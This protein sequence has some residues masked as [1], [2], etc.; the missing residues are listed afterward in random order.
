M[1]FMNL[2]DLQDL[3][4]GF[5]DK[6]PEQEAQYPKKMLDGLFPNA[7]YKVSTEDFAR[8]QECAKMLEKYVSRFPKETRYVYFDSNDMSRWENDF[9]PKLVHGGP[10][11]LDDQFYTGNKSVMSCSG[12]GTDGAFSCEEFFQFL[13]RVYKAMAHYK[14]QSN[15]AAVMQGLKLFS[16]AEMLEKYVDRFPAAKGCVKLEGKDLTDWKEHFFPDLVED[17][18]KL[19]DYT[20]FNSSNKYCGIGIDGEFAAAELFQFM[21]RL[22]KEIVNKLG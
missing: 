1:D 13:Y 12:I 15:M 9:F 18:P 7:G 21:Y 19:P 22:Y 16:C 6:K 5:G 17:G 4:A 8:M 2:K 11:L 3:A 14:V 10:E 20:F